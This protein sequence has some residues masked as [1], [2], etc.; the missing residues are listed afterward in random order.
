MADSSTLV[1]RGRIWDA[2]HPIHIYKSP[3]SADSAGR[4]SRY[5][6][7]PP[8]ATTP[9]HRRLCIPQ[10]RQLNLSHTCLTSRRDPHLGLRQRVFS[11][12]GTSAI[13]SR[14]INTLAVPRLLSQR[15]VATTRPYPASNSSFFGVSLASGPSAS[16]RLSWST[17]PLFPPCPKL[18]LSDDIRHTVPTYSHFDSQALT[19]SP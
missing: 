10:W 15:R 3:M 14:G 19:P 1:C 7:S 12:R 2:R 4:L 9:P 17:F 6:F 8:A 5:P 11:L 18:P 16:L 13:E